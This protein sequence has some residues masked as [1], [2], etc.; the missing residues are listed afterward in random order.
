MAARLSLSEKEDILLLKSQGKSFRSIGV[1][2]GRSHQTIRYVCDSDLLKKMLNHNREAMKANPEKHRKLGRDYAAKHRI[3]RR[4]YR[5]NYYAEHRKEE[6]ARQKEY[7][8][9]NAEIV[10]ERQAKWRLNNKERCKIVASA[11]RNTAAGRISSRN[12][13]NKR[14]ERKEHGAGITVK[15]VDSLWNDQ[16]GKCFYC[17]C[18]MRTAK[19]FNGPVFIE[20]PYLENDYCTLD[21]VIPLSKNGLHE[22]E[23]IVLACRKCNI[24]K[25]IKENVS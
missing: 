6:L 3:E 20:Y 2:V 5:N 8:K 7:V 11:Y 10:S 14:R 12:A 1:I 25:E 16:D 21:H 19:D 9:D 15:D 13:E 22:I 24:K 17:G 4:K 18:S 23:N